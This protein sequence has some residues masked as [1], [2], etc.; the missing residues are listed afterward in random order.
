VSKLN[1]IPKEYKSDIEKATNILKK[2]SCK[3]I[4]L[5]GSLAEGT[6][7]SNSDINLA[8]ENC[9]EGNFFLIY[10][11]LMMALDHSIDLVNLGNKDTF[12]EFLKNGNELI[13][14]A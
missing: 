13:L 12:S 4:Y 6:S 7:N 3:A 5:F 14:V 11:E 2:H 1:N 9:P 10:A 8:V